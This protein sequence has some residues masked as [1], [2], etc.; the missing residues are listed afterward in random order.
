MQCFCV[1]F[2]TVSCSC[3][4]GVT[5]NLHSNHLVVQGKRYLLFYL[6]FRLCAVHVRIRIT[7]SSFEPTCPPGPSSGIQFRRFLE[8]QLRE[9]FLNLLFIHLFLLLSALKI[10]IYSLSKFSFFPCFFERFLSS[11]LLRHTLLLFRQ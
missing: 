5:E 10:F 7:K 8:F 1:R 11:S 6:E 2:L 3:M 9:F 4:S